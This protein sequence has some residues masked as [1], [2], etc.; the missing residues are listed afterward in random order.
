[1]KRLFPLNLLLALGFSAFMCGAQ[2]PK[3][4]DAQK[5]K[6][7]AKDK[8]TAVELKVSVARIEIIQSVLKKYYDKHVDLESKET[9]EDIMKDIQEK[10]PVPSKPADNR[11]PLAIQQSTESKVAAKFPKGLDQV[12]KEAEIEAEK[13]FP[14]VKKNDPIKVYYR[15]GGRMMAASGRFSGYGLG[16]KTIRI[17]STNI[18][19]FD[20]TP[21]S[22]AMFDREANASHK[23]EFIQK[24]V[25][26]YQMDR[27]R[28]ADQLYNEE[29]TSHSSQLQCSRSIAA[30][31]T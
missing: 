9:Q 11:S 17:N 22:K 10:I 14:L 20:L 25:R 3:D 27:R 7:V 15:R 13:K 1:M 18:P 26:E 31:P 19:I 6:R 23:R 24:Q 4:K 8:I 16:G 21:E 28:Y 30:K 2:E 5:P 12:R 29:K